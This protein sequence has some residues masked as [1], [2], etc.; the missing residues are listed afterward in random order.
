MDAP[1]ADGN[2]ATGDAPVILPFSAGPADLGQAARPARIL[3]LINGEHYSG[4][5][6]VQD[7]LAQRLPDFGY[8]AGL[9]C[10]KKGRFEQMRQARQ[11]PLYLTPMQSRWDFSI[12][13]TLRKIVRQDGYQLLHAHTPRSV[14][15]GTMLSRATGVPLLFHVHS[16]T[17]HDSTRRWQ[18]KL[19]HWIEKESLRR[20][21]RLVAVSHSLADHMARAGYAAEKITVVHNGVPAAP[22]PERRP[23]GG[24]WTLGSVAL[25]RP[26]K[27]VEILLE[28][29]SRLVRQKVDVQLRAVGPFET[30]EY[31]SQIR[32]RVHKLGLGDRVTWTGFTSQV[33]NEL[34]QMDLFILPSLFGEGLP[35]VVLE[36]MACGTPVLATR[37]EGTPEAIR[38]GIDGWLVPAGSP[39]DLADA[40]AGIVA[41]ADCWNAARSSAH[42]RQ[43]QYFSDVSMAR[44]MADVYDRLLVPNSR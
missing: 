28:A 12:V 16:P 17:S 5:E 10:L 23:P 42:L 43:Q 32:D 26:R 20:A 40:V 21:E 25:F 11:S 8:Q 19:N 34:R 18:N 31:E 30:A 37:V 22:L 3:H 39:A 29:M 38:D 24:P 14:M 36:A 9:V 27:G 15:I 2:A 1:A 35:M 7:L 6:R 13:R 33:A 41:D 4:A 44:G